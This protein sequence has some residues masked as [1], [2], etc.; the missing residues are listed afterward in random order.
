MVEE[1]KGSKELRESLPY[2][3]INKMALIFK[4][5]PAY[6]AQVISGFKKGNPLIIECAIKVS[7]LNYELQDKLD[8]ILKDYEAAN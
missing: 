2:G 7:D 4:Y 6:V 1:L 8:A 5:T 3:A